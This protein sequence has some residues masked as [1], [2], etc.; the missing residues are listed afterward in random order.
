MS[1]GRFVSSKKA[2][3]EFGSA[4]PRVGN[5]D[6]DTWIDLRQFVVLGEV[7]HDSGP[8]RNTRLLCIDGIRGNVWWVYPTRPRNQQS[9]ACFS[10]NSN[11]T[12]YLA[13]LLAYKCFREKWW[14]LLQRFADYDEEVPID[15]PAYVREAEAMHAQFLERLQA[16]DSTHFTG[17]FW[18]DHAWNEH[19][20]MH[21]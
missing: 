17:G 13:S 16:V 1:P 11:V 10:L 15:D 4:F 8:G 12:A 14:E 19:I 2:D 21:S 9:T 5:P 20:L 7:Q 6:L 18:E 3:F